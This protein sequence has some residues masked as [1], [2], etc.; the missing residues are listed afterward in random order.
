MIIKSIEPVN[1]DINF[2]NRFLK[3]GMMNDY[4]FESNFFIVKFID[5]TKQDL[6]YVIYRKLWESIYLR[7]DQK[8]F[9]E[10][11]DD[12]TTMN[13]YM[14]LSEAISFITAAAPPI[15]Q[16]RIKGLLKS[17]KDIND[18]LNEL[19][20]SDNDPHQSYR[21]DLFKRQLHLSVFATKMEYDMT[22]F[23]KMIKDK[24]PYEHTPILG[25]IDNCNKSLSSLITYEHLTGKYIVPVE[26]QATIKINS[27]EDY[28]E[29]FRFL[30]NFGRIT[31]I[32][33]DVN[34]HAVTVYFEKLKLDQLKLIWYWYYN[35]LNIK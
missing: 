35:K 11:N 5:L 18:S 12:A 4:V 30:S 2:I 13:L 23:D 19:L 20:L 9:C 26:M 15:L 22:K 17:V 14:S 28:V 3:M 25:R 10:L 21:Y 1:M 33:A 27:Q 24:I 8:S 31:N 16:S 6:Y 32:L 7:R 34:I 29:L